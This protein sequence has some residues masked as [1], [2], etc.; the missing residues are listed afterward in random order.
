MNE[1]LKTCLEYNVWANRIITGYIEKAGEQKLDFVIENSFPSIRKTWYHI[2]DAQ[3]VWIRR[4]EG[5]EV[6]TWPSRDFNG[7]AKEAMDQFIESSEKFLELGSQLNPE[8][9]ITYKSMAG[10][11][12]TSKVW[13]ILMHVV[14]H[15]TYHRGQMVTMLRQAGMKELQPLDLIVFMRQS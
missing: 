14:N 6:T 12:F 7:T 11:E 10:K 4:L 8:T 5:K 9:A 3:E 15:G 13:H 1:Y 2:W